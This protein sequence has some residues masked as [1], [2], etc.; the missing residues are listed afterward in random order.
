MSN[1]LQSLNANHIPGLELKDEIGLLSNTFKKLLLEVQTK[2]IQTEEKA[3]VDGLTGVYNRNKFDE[4]FY[5]EMVRIQRYPTKLSIAIIDIDRFKKCNDTY[6]HLIGDEVLIMIAKKINTTIRSTDLF[7]RWGGEE[8]VI[9]FKE[10]SAE[11]AK[12]VSKNLKDEIQKLQH[13][14]A[15]NLTASFGITQYIKG[16]TMESIFKRCDD[17]LYIAKE[18]GRNRIEV[19]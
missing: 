11:E 12:I 5:E 3:Y 7:A 16:D 2:Q 9:L 10:T 19:L 13:Q 8:F 17:A 4:V 6:G 15:G 14:I 18:Q 1:D